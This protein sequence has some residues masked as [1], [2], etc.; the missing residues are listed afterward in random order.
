MVLLI[1]VISGTILLWKNPLLHIQYPQLLTP[2]STLPTADFLAHL[3]QQLP[4]WRTVRLPEPDQPYYLVYRGEQKWY[5]A[6]DG[7]WLLTRDT[8]TD[9]L[10]F[11][12]SLHHH[13]LL[14]EFGDTVL[15]FVSIGS[16]LLLLLG[17]YQSWPRA[18]R[19]SQMLQWR[20]QQGGIARWYTSHRSTGLIFSLL[21][22]LTVVT[23]L[24]LSFH[25]VPARWLASVDSKQAPAPISTLSSPTESML[26]WATLLAAGTQAIPDAR[27][28]M[29]SRPAG[30]DKPLTLRLQVPDE[31]HP[32][33]RGGVQLHPGSGEVLSLY[34]VRTVGPA[35]RLA[36]TMYPLHAGK[37]GGLGYQIVLALSSIGSLFLAWSALRLWRK[38]RQRSLECSLSP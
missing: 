32:N 14:G 2:T 37:V 23:G 7:Q 13:L 9:W 34:D 11:T 4:D 29:V 3:D 16:L 31:W 8:D 27:L 26:P 10:A 35:T 36:N 15:G 21:L 6:L 28:T 24:M 18:Q 30:P 20:W 5:Y 33:G 17:L 38:R 12:E 22:G 25:G 19:W 1:L